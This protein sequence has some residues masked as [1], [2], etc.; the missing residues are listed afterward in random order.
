MS[1]LFCHDHRFVIDASGNVC[2]RGQYSAQ[3]VARYEQAFG[4]MRIAGREQ[5]LVPELSGR[6]NVLFSDRTRFVSLP[7]LSSLG[8]LLFGDSH[9]RQ[10]LEKAVADADVVVV[11]LP[12][13][14]GLLA[15]EIA[16][17]QRKPLIVEVVACVWDGLMSHGS[18]VARTY[19]PLAFRRMQMSVAQSE[20]TVYVTQDFLQSR[21]P[22]RGKQLGVSDVQILPHD[23]NVLRRRLSALSHDT[24]RLTFGMIAAMFHNEKR[25]DIAIR[26][27][28]LASQEADNLRLEIVGSGNTND[29]QAL[30]ARLGVGNR[31]LFRGVLPHGEKLFSW[32]DDID[33][34][35]QT[36]FQEGLPRALIEAMSRA[37]P[38]LASSAG[39]TNE[40][41]SDEWRHD[42]GDTKHL[43]AQMLR[44]RDK[45]I[46]I[47]L[48]AENHATA[49]AYAPGKLD[50]LRR[51][52][53]SRFCVAN[54]IPQE[55]TPQ[56]ECPDAG[57]SHND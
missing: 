39:G 24:E 28:A 4:E 53:W 56:P 40:L 42:P 23:P 19:A 30:A 3:I 52:F 48:A 46:R 10:R 27:L 37:A 22:A 12:S 34:Y 41:V 11:R 38:A 15:A 2:S 25:V 13:E 54:R 29:L 6:L 45:N 50:L 55:T 20:W 44:L 49:A 36:S 33:V 32:I 9:A 16:R 1:V 26:A 57:G 47:R 35:V 18:V 14:I 17:R 5:R 8:A 31:V 51:D 43:A 21:Y 7:N